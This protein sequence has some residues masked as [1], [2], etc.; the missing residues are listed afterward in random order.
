MQD[1]PFVIAMVVLG[2]AVLYLLRLNRRHQQQLHELLTL[3]QAAHQRNR[4]YE[5]TMHTAVNV[6]TKLQSLQEHQRAV[7]LNMSKAA[8]QLQ[9]DG[10]LEAFFERFRQNLWSYA[11]R[12]EVE[13]ALEQLR[14]DPRMKG[15]RFD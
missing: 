14:N 1:L 15:I 6:L 8:N 10:D 12:M 7:L 5:T 4:E 11:D 9:S 3:L 13:L 2:A